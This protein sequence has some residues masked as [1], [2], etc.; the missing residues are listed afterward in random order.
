MECT[1]L[2]IRGDD[3]MFIAGVGW[4]EHHPLR[5]WVQRTIRRVRETHLYTC[6]SLLGFWWGWCVPLRPRNP[7]QRLTVDQ[8]EPRRRHSMTVTLDRGFLPPVEVFLGCCGA[9][10]AGTPKPNAPLWARLAHAALQGGWTTEDD[11]EGA[12]IE[13]V[14]HA[15]A[16]AASVDAPSGSRVEVWYDP[17][18][19][20]HAAVSYT[21]CRNTNITLDLLNADEAQITVSS[22]RAQSVIDRIPWHAAEGS[23]DTADAK[24]L[25]EAA[26][27]ERIADLE[28]QLVEL[29][30][31]SA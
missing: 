9:P 6:Y 1:L 14:E 26:H 13:V 27:A 16:L 22:P 4:D 31:A 30:R 20:H 5:P 11:I 7:S 17:D 15:A 3:G 2:Q 23:L 29:R 10:P 28:A 18:N 25:Y 12:P 19:A 8:E 24:A 21:T